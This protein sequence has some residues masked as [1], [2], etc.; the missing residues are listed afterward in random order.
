MTFAIM[1]EKYLEIISTKPSIKLPSPSPKLVILDLNGTL[2]CRRKT[3]KAKITKVLLRPFLNEFLRYI[4]FSGNFLVMIWSSIR[5]ENVEL[6]IK[7]AFG[8]LDKHLL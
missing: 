3:K 4:F 7:E 5:P 8:D 1:Y 6:I 2:V